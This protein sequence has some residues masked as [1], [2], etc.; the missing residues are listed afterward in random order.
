[1][2]DI[3]GL[4]LRH[5]RTIPQLAAVEFESIALANA[6]YL[7]AVPSRREAPFTVRWM[8]GLHREMLGSV[9][10]WAGKRRTTEGWN[11]GVA[12]IQI[13]TMLEDL[14]RDVAY[15]RSSAGK[16]HEY[17]AMLHHRAVYIHP[18][19]NGNGRWARLLS[20]IW[21]FQETGTYTRWPERDLFN[22]RSTL[23]TEYMAALKAAD[24]G[25]FEALVRM[26]E[27]YAS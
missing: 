10:S 20:Q 21:Q 12:V 5:V 19:L 2:D 3:S 4:R 8:M 26:H 23:R 7:A 22:G 16:R 9:W 14:S 18:F 24:N 27:E 15:W 13:E 17:A 6:K 25:Y 11:I 1:M